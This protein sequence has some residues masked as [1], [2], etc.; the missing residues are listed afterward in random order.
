MG[1]RLAGYGWMG[2]GANS[3]PSHPPLAGRF[4]SGSLR[5]RSDPAHGLLLPVSFLSQGFTRSC[6][7]S[8]KAGYGLLVGGVLVD[9]A[10]DGRVDGCAGVF[11]TC[12]TCTK[13]SPFLIMP[14]SKRARSSMASR[15]D[16]KSRTSASSAALRCSRVW[17]CARCASSCRLLS[18]TRNQ[19]PLPSHNGYCSKAMRATSSQVNRL[20]A[21]ISPDGFSFIYANYKTRP[22]R[23]SWR[24]RPGLLQCAA[25]GCIWRCGLSGKAIPF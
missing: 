13:N 21:W 1:L 20:M 3:R 23:G 6:K 8:G 16:F 11:G 19:P 2:G 18:H 22:S 4:L 9:A 5:E 12:G 24:C 17:F 14:R 25:T 10:E 15:P 7:V